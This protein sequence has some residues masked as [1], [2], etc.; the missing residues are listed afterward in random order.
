MDDDINQFQNINE[1]TKINVRYDGELG[2]DM[3]GLSRDL[4]SEFRGSF[5]RKFCLGEEIV[6]LYITACEP[7]SKPQKQIPQ[8]IYQN[9]LRILCL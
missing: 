5:T 7:H 3:A 1:L 6:Y 2:E 9:S 4:F 8:P